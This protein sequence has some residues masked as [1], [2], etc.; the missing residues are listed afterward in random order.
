MLRSPHLIPRIDRPQLHDARLEALPRRAAR[1]ARNQIDGIR[2]RQRGGGAREQA[3]QDAQPFGGRNDEREAE[4]GDR[5]LT[6]DRGK[7]MGRG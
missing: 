7:K 1:V 5:A 2:E 3:E 6:D 4:I